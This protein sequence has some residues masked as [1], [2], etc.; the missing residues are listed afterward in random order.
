MKAIWLEDGRAAWRDVPEPERRPGW[1]VVQVSAVGVCNTDL[2]LT[3]GYMNFRG[4][5]GHE[6]VGRVVSD[7]SPLAGRRVVGEINTGCGRCAACLAGWARHCAERGVLGILNL[8]GAFAERIALP[9]GNLK[10]IPDSL[11]DERA[12]FIEPLAAALRLSE[13]GL[14]TA[15]TRTLLVGDGKLAQL[16]A[17]VLALHGARTTVLGR[18]A[19]K[20]DLLAPWVN[21]IA[22]D[23]QR[24][25][26]ASFDLVIEASGSPAGMAAAL[27]TVRPMGTIVVKSTC[28][29]RIDLDLS[30][31]VVDE[32]RLVGSRC[33]PFEPAID[34]LARGLVDPSPLIDARF[35]FRET[36]EALRHA[37]T[38]GVLKVVVRF[39]ASP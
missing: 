24:V 30:R 19:R 4:V 3:R 8:P 22:R 15:G 28:A 17:R 36:I 33:G 10:P 38:P 13:Q 1:D 5:P 9:R 27:A 35:D 20:L 7:D 21:V 18:H 32:V 12:V 37:A 16:V 11:D 34:L 29:G 25:A 23:A 2:E 31:C 39:P 14:L 6:F 26:P